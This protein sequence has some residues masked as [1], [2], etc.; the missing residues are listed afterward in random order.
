[1]SALLSTLLDILRLR[2]GP[3]D[4]PASWAFAIAM[5]LLYL[6][7]GVFTGQSL[8]DDNPAST[9]IALASLQFVAVAV[10]LYIRKFTERLPQTLG[11][12]AGAGVILGFVS[13]LLL[14]Q[15]DPGQQQPVLAMAWFAV[16]FWSLVVDGHIYRHALSISLQQGI[17]IAV[18]LL[19]ASYVLVEFYLTPAVAA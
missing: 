9:S 6:M 1:M 14:A 12:L 7:F 8:G 5:L 15:A 17:L 2:K 19:A 10:M 18:L 4:L 3:Q 16:F 11:A 13:F